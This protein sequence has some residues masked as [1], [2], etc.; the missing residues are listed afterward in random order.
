M[1]AMINISF[2]FNQF[3][4]CMLE[5]TRQTTHYKTDIQYFKYFSKNKYIAFIN[6]HKLDLYLH[7]FLNKERMWRNW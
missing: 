4:M 2:F 6:L 1:K 7:P 3:W 5:K